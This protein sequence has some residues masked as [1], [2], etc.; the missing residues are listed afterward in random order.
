MTPIVDDWDELD[1]NHDTPRLHD[2]PRCRSVDVEK[3]LP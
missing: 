2:C 3:R 1:C